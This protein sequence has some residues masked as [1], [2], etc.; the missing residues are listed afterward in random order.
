MKLKLRNQLI[1]PSAIGLV[2][3]VIISTVVFSNLNTLLSNSGWVEHTYKVIANADEVMAYMV[4][5]ETGMRGFAV[6]GDEEFLAPYKSGGTNFSTAIKELQ[7]T[8]NDNPTQVQRLRQIEQ[9][10]ASWR[11]DVAEKYI[12]LRRNIKDGEDERQRMFELIE[13]GVGKRNMDNLRT[14]VAR[15]SMIAQAKD[16]IILDMVNMET[17]LRGFM[18]NSKEEF[19]EPYNEGKAMIENDFIAFSAPASVKSAAR[20]WINDYAERAIAI[21]REA[22]KTAEMSQLY[23]EFAKK[24]GKK[25]M[26]EIR[27]LIKTFSSEEESLLVVRREASESTASTTKNLL[28]FITIAAIIISI[29]I[30]LYVSGKVL[31]DIGG[32]PDEVAR[33]TEQVSNG[34]LSFDYNLD[35]GS[36]G[37]YKAIINMSTK[38]KD[39]IGSVVEASEQM[40]ASSNTLRENSV[41]ISSGVSEQA[42]SAEEV[43][44]SM[45][46][47][48]ANIQQNTENAN[49]T[50]QMS[51]KASTSIEEVAVASED[52]MAAV[53]D[54]YSKINIVVEIAE[55]TDLLAINAAVEAARAGDEGR[56]FAVVA[57][58]VRKL[59]ERS[60]NAA[61][62]IVA[63]AENGLKLTEESTSKLKAIVPDIQQTSQLVNEIASASMEQETGANQVNSAI[64]ELNNVTQQNA[65]SSEEMSSSSE[66]LASLAN[67]LKDVTSF[68]KI[69]KHGQIRRNTLRKPTAI[70]K[71]ASFK[72]SNG[73]GHSNGS[74]IDLGN[75][76]ESLE[77]YENI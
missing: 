28:I 49:K 66:E 24:E 39:I 62:E 42:A 43:S 35:A 14:L 12:D 25:Y 69:E 46:E 33:I 10:A 32:E 20:N 48:A 5:Q 61:S 65:S 71:P 23:A 34:D 58:E 54:I 27:S 70:Q 16:K 21:N 2:L 67:D 19:L 72:H 37:I 64:Q 73:N 17:G 1:L 57:A 52:S 77:D 18:L 68:F 59:A 63:L 55:K 56:G 8:V 3:M 44:S 22:M 60:Q 9:L 53:R 45:E 29:L 11:S 26:D 50:S 31:K 41:A 74:L 4:D 36:S 6:S 15:S 30:V 40:A 38:L 13:S 75:V 47:M 51:N 76:N 7:E